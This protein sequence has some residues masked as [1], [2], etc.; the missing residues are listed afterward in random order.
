MQPQSQREQEIAK[1]AWDQG[2]A[3]AWEAGWSQNPYSGPYIPA[4]GTN[5][6]PSIA[7]PSASPGRLTPSQQRRQKEKEAVKWWNDRNKERYNDMLY[8]SMGG[9]GSTERTSSNSW[10]LSA[11]VE[12]S[13]TVT[14]ASVWQLRQQSSSRTSWPRRT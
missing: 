4:A 13:R 9:F 10:R 11:E 6:R 5:T 3:A 12:G 1:M 14:A 8:L 2:S 7:L